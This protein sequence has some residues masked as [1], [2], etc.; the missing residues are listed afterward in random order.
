MKRTFFLLLLMTI[1]LSA[2]MMNAT[3]LAHTDGDTVIFDV[4]G[5]KL[6]CQLDGIDAPELRTTKKMIR[7]AKRAYVG[8]D[9]MQTLGMDAFVYMRNT[10]V[11]GVTYRVDAVRGYHKDVRRCMVYLPGQRRSL[12]ER[13][14]VDGY[15]VMDPKSIILKEIRA[16]HTFAILEQ[17]AASDGAGLWKEH[18]NTMKAISR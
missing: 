18:Y 7:D 11:R 4:N 13:A 9:K 10:F 2:K 12:N 16:K 17:S 3:Y 8:Y 5:K 15:A 1:P 14:I 6:L